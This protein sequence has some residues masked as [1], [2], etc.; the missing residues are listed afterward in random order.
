MTRPIILCAAIALLL[1][2]ASHAAHTATGAPFTF[3][4]RTCDSGWI[5]SETLKKC[6]RLPRGSYDGN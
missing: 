6:V 5:W 4:K 2:H 1:G 3:A